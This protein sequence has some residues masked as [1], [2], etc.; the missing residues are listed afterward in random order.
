MTSGYLRRVHVRPELIGVAADYDRSGRRPTD[1][2]YNYSETMI[3]GD[4]REIVATCVGQEL[5]GL[6][7]KDHWVM[8]RPT[9]G[10]NES[11]RGWH[12][13]VGNLVVDLPGEIAYA[14]WERE[15]A[16][17]LFHCYSDR[18]WLVV[19]DCF[20]FCWKI[21]WGEGE[22]QLLM[23]QRLP[24]RAVL[25]MA[26]SGRYLAVTTEHN[27]VV[28]LRL[29][30]KGAGVEENYFKVTNKISNDIQFKTMCYHEPTDQLLL[31]DYG[32]YLIRVSFN[33]A[34]G[35]VEE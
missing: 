25:A 14:G 11:G 33:P 24:S 21:E 13:R 15:V 27:T 12:G 20:I 1:C 19:T 31:S 28:V 6:V 8:V 35:D 16:V 7:T 32:A 10:L 5:V 17:V 29:E 2:W 34:Y 4:G 22:S 23:A 30:L 9:E 18:E 26:L 3:E